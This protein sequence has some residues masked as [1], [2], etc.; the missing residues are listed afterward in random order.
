MTITCRFFTAGQPARPTA[1]PIQT[2]ALHTRP[3]RR[4]VTEKGIRST[5]NHK[6]ETAPYTFPPAAGK[7]RESPLGITRGLELAVVFHFE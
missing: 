3:V 6:E 4:T 5:E 1:N 2:A 7:R